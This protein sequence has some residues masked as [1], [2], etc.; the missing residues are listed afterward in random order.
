MEEDIPSSPESVTQL[1]QKGEFP[2]SKNLL[3][4][5]LLL[6]DDNHTDVPEAQLL[7]RVELS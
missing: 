1:P 3:V 2:F 5:L 7:S 6:V 4:L